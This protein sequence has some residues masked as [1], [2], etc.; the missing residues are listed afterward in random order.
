LSATDQIIEY[1]TPRTRR[2][3]Q[4]RELRRALFKWTKWLGVFLVSVLLATCAWGGCETWRVYRMQEEFHAAGRVA[5]PQ[6]VRRLY[7]DDENGAL[8]LRALGGSVRSDNAAWAYLDNRL[9]SFPLE[10]EEIRDLHAVLADNELVLRQ[11]A[12]ALVETRVDWGLRWTQPYNVMSMPHLN[13]QRDLSTL[14]FYAAMEAHHRGDDREALER[15]VQM[16][17]LSLRL[18]QEPVLMQHL[19][20]RGERANV[21]LAVREIVPGLKIGD[22]PPAASEKQVHDLIDRL[23]DDRAEMRGMRLALDGQQM[24][25]VD[26]AKHVELT[27][28]NAPVKL[29]DWFWG[30]A[31]EPMALHDSITACRY[32]DALYDALKSS[33]DLPAFRGKAPAA[34]VSSAV[35]VMYMYCERDREFVEEHY[36][37]LTDHHL[38]ATALG[39]RLYYAKNQKWPARLE[40]VA[41]ICLR[42]VPRDEMGS[43]VAIAYKADARR[44][45]IYSVGTDCLDDGG[46]DAFIGKD[47]F[48]V[49]HMKDVV[50]DLTPQPRRFFFVP[51]IEAGAMPA[52]AP[53]ATQQTR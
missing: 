52:G 46:D 27:G 1:A 48:S 14:L 6:D 15:V 11:I 7:E 28:S 17:D 2:A 40:D 44:P 53:P 9:L 10:L 29:D 4:W 25:I 21:C 41:P 37:H 32:L 51:Y 47:G 49:W 36:R 22:A 39:M 42:Y 26:Q 5:K 12:P 38:A 19:V 3:G 33:A 43:S 30:R 8:R 31:M 34:L 45:I 35:H 18:D 23:L 24:C 13:P 20:A 16:W 50:V